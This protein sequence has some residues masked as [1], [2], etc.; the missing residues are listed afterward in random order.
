MSV[1]PFK[2]SK[3]NIAKC[4][5]LAKQEQNVE[6]LLRRVQVGGLVCKEFDSRALSKTTTKPVVDTGAGGRIR[7]SKDGKVH[8]LLRPARLPVP[9]HLLATM[10]SS[11]GLTAAISFLFLRMTYQRSI[12]PRVYARG[13]L[14]CCYN[15]SKD[16][17]NLTDC[18][19]L[20]HSDN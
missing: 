16:S 14:E 9:P 6:V 1:T 20:W 17:L 12:H 5:V 3:G 4:E 18:N 11:H 19:H 13:F 8:K 7:T 2:I 15:Y 10:T